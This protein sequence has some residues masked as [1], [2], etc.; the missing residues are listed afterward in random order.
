MADPPLR[1]LKIMKFD[2]RKTYY[3]VLDTETCPL[4]TGFDKVEPTNM[5][6]YDIG[7]RII[8][9]KGNCYLE[10]SYV[11]DEIFFGEYDRML[12]SYYA[13]K[14]PQYFSDL[15]NG[16]RIRKSFWEIRKDLA[17]DMKQFNCKIVAAHNARFDVGALN[18]TIKFLFPTS[19]KK[20]YF[21]PY[22]TTIW[23]TMKMARDTICK[24]NTYCFYTPS[25]RKSAKAEDLYR[26]I[27][28]EYDFIESHTGLEDTKIESA[29]LVKCLATHKKMT[30]ELYPKKK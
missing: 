18:T 29:I 11:V 9:K 14:L 12:S 1:K 25:G 15:G 8:D 20:L 3:C 27:S 4:E 30:K 26:Y 13:S 24:Y 22:D 16:S 6:V 5:L 2:R 21:F 7:Y 28:H 17:E 23:D 10:K 19:P